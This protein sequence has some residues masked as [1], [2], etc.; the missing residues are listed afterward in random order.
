MSSSADTS[1]DSM[2]LDKWVVS[3]RSER[4]RW[5]IPGYLTVSWMNKYPLDLIL[6]L[7]RFYDCTTIEVDIMKFEEILETSSTDNMR[8]RCQGWLR[9]RMQEPEN[10][11]FHAAWP[12]K[13]REDELIRREELPIG[14]PNP[15]LL[16]IWKAS[17]IWQAVIAPRLKPERMRDS[18]YLETIWEETKGRII[19]WLK[20]ALTPASEPLVTEDTMRVK[21]SIIAVLIYTDIYG[22]ANDTCCKECL[23]HEA[24]DFCRSLKNEVVIPFA[25]RCGNCLAWNRTPCG[26]FALSQRNALLFSGVTTSSRDYRC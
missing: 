17:I 25:S 16:T 13:Q 11:W 6:E 18:R 1:A 10:L 9:A 7:K 22:R 14:C 20:A 5:I 23:D 19:E 12:V 8:S 4:L 2:T 3:S 15:R 26:T 21:S 24:S